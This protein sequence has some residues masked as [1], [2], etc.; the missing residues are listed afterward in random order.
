MSAST[1]KPS[2]TAPTVWSIFEGDMSFAT[3]TLPQVLLKQYERLFVQYGEVAEERDR[4]K[5][6]LAATQQEL[7]LAEDLLVRYESLDLDANSTDFH[8]IN[9]SE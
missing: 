2:L 7:D 3:E 6:L 4:L 1:A 5:S 8:R 9:H